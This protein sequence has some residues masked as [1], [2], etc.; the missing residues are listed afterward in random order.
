M[1]SSSR[2][3][4]IYQ[5]IKLPSV[6]DL[7]QYIHHN[8]RYTQR[9]RQCEARI[10]TAIHTDEYTYLLQRQQHP[11]VQYALH[12]L[13]Y[14]YTSRRQHVHSIDN[15]NNINNTTKFPTVALALSGG[16]YRA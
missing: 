15:N 13:R 4:S 9:P 8:Q 5:N 7:L 11:D 12:Q 2:F 10:G 16:G 1:T 3:P 6:T 14:S